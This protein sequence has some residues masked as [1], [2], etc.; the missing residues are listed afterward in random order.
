[1]YTIRIRKTARVALQKMTPKRAARIAGIVERIA[2]D[3]FARHPNV[4]RIKGEK[5]GFRY[6]LG[7]WRVLYRL[8]SKTK[9]LT[10]VNIRPRGS[11]YE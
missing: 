6:R 5:G 9:T 7:D 4:D 8:D 1:M 2:A 10:L 3:P 11:A